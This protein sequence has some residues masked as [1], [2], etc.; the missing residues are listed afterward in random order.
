M[1]LFL[2]RSTSWRDGTTDNGLTNDLDRANGTLQ[3]SQEISSSPTG[4]GIPSND[5]NSIKAPIAYKKS[6]DEDSNLPE[7]A[8]ESVNISGSFDYGGTF[9]AS[10][11][12]HDSERGGGVNVNIGNERNERRENDKQ[13]QN[14]IENKEILENRKE[15]I[16]NSE[17]SPVKFMNFLNDDTPPP[18][19]KPSPVPNEIANGPT[20]PAPI[21]QMDKMVENF[22]ANLIM[23]DDTSTMNSVKAPPAPPIEWFYRD[24]QGDTQGPFS[25]GDMSEW[26]KAGYF[27]ESL[28]VRRSI[29]STFTPLGHLVKIFGASRPFI[30]ACLDGGPP[31]PLPEVMD[32]FRMRMMPPQAP[33]APVPPVQPDNWS[34][35]TAEQRMFFMQ[36][37]THQPRPPV[38]PY[39]M[40]QPQAPSN[41]QID[42]RRLM[43]GDFY[44]QT[45]QQQVPQQPPPPQQAPPPQPQ[46]QQ[47]TQQPEA[48]PIHQLIMQLQMQQKTGGVD[49]AQWIKP[50]QQ[51][52]QQPEMPPQMVQQHQQPPPQQQQQQQQQQ[53]NSTSSTH[54]SGTPMNIWD[55]GGGNKEQQHQQQQSM[56]DIQI[57]QHQQQQQQQQSDPDIVQNGVG[58]DSQ[59]QMQKVESKKKKKEVVKEQQQQQAP[60][61]VKEQPKDKKQPVPV[62]KKKQEK[63]KEERTTQPAAPAPW[64]GHQ[65]NVSG[66]S[67]TKIQK[68]EAQRR[69]IELAQ[70][71]ER[72]QKQLEMMV[73]QASENRDVKWNLQ[74]PPAAQVKTLD[75]IQAEEQTAA[76]REER[77]K[78]KHEKKEVVIVGDIWNTGAHSMAWQ[79]PKA[80]TGGQSNSGFWEDPV[81]QP[82]QPK[83]APQMLS[84][85]QTMATISTAK[86][87]VQQAQQAQA[88][89]QQKKQEANNI[90]KKVEKKKDENNEFTIWCTRTLSA[91]NGNVDSELKFEYF[92]DS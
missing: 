11:A 72:E 26:Y 27:Q 1:I 3:S 75:E 37:A 64:V 57:A 4:G 13:Q 55:L 54:W 49:A 92:L 18:Q 19:Q 68:T 69:Q 5:G 42:I 89:A 84:K 45:Q 66:P 28:M 85:S 52:T 39:V 79:Q 2:A 87:Q 71:K 78:A 12:F 47:Q 41:P 91:M 23:D 10:G 58:D 20:H 22:V 33:I 17:P 82:A 59:H 80:W 61:A 67:L 56:H 34:L 16:E 29:D 83:Q 7:W 88:V 30:A 90:K 46:Q 48:D 65:N 73:K 81:K 50:S 35:M 15:M 53:Q 43:G 36:L 77:A 86:R 74:M 70:Q 60:Q 51:P 8:T 25:S 14:R 38:D 32:P 44:Q 63:K 24:P 6:W 31:I 40:K 9:D 21:A 62:E 76:E